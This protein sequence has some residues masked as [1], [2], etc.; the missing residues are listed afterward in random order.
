MFVVRW[1]SLAV[2]LIGFG[3]FATCSSDEPDD[4]EPPDA[5]MPVVD[6]FPDAEAPDG[7]DVCVGK[8]ASCANGQRC[9]Q[10]L[11]CCGGPP[12]PTGEDFCE[13]H[14]PLPM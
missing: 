2:V 4:P 3:L 11:T 6:D 8:A 14:C 9:C 1:C 5:R 13:E 7:P 10:G 12:I